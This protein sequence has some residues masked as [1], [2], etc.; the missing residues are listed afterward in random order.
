VA[1][2]VITNPSS[3]VKGA[4]LKK[5]VSKAD[6]DANYMNSGI[7]PNQYVVVAVYENSNDPKGAVVSLGRTA[8]AVF[9][10]AFSANGSP[11]TGALTLD[12]YYIQIT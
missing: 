11:Y 10:Y 12:F 6:S 9:A 1:N 3:A 5:T 4:I 2:S 7:N 8:G